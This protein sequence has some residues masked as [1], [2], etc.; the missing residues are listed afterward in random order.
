LYLEGFI[1]LIRLGAIVPAFDGFEEMFIEG[2]SGEA[3]SALG[4]LLGQ[5]GSDGSVVV[6][7][8]KAYFDYQSFRTQARLF[9]AIGDRSVSFSR[10]ALDRWSKTQFLAYAQKRHVAEAQT[11]YE[12][13]SARLST[14]HPLLTRAVL[15]RRLLDIATDLK[16]VQALA[17]EL[18]LKPRDYFQQFVKAIITR[19]ASDKWLDK[20]GKEGQMLLSVD[21]HLELLAAIAQEMWISSTESLRLDVIDVIT[22]M[23]CEQAKLSPVFSRQIKER[24]KTHALLVASTAARGGLSFDHEDFR[25][26]F[27]G[28][29]LG[30]ILRSGN[31]EDIRSFLRVS[32]ISPEMADEAVFDFMRSGRRAVEGIGVLQMLSSS[33]SSA[34]FLRDNVGAIAIRLIDGSEIKN[35]T[36]VD[37]TFP[38]QALSG[39]TLGDCHFER[40]YF[41]PTSLKLATLSGT[42]FSHCKFERLE[43]QDAKI[44]GVRFEECDVVCFASSVDDEIAYGPDRIGELL[45]KAG[46]D[47]GASVGHKAAASRTDEDIILLE[48]ILRAF[49]RST[50]ISESVMRIKL[51]AR[52]THFIN[53]IVPLLVRAG[54]F[55][56]V[57]HHGSGSMRRFK[58]GI[59]MSRIDE[60]LA[61]SS[62]EFDEFVRRLT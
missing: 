32:S 12:I 46:V 53:E 9:D 37:M 14:Q 27:L 43:F 30:K 29:A 42:T 7:A 18:G 22:D 8:R 25:H 61:Q 39:R 44:S 49:L 33:E 4:S 45:R 28:L 41:L 1:E 56:E 57:A 34:S 15:V 38:S 35:L 20:E 40:C 47:M 11:I 17:A 31:H 21:G 58:L 62:G 2:S 10:L 52:A 60:T 51:G 26:F 54:V 55:Q 36:L 13:V 23:F 3:I 24:V 5:L 19:E 50:Q 59:P 48:R 16:D 6:A